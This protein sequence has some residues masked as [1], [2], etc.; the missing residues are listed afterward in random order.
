MGPMV[1]LLSSALQNRNSRSKD[2]KRIVFVLQNPCTWPRSRRWLRPCLL[3]QKLKKPIFKRVLNKSTRSRKRG[4]LSM[5]KKKSSTSELIDLL[6][7][8][9]NWN[10]SWLSWFIICFWDHFHLLQ[11]LEQYVVEADHLRASE[12]MLLTEQTQL[13]EVRIGAGGD[14]PWLLLGFYDKIS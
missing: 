14:G 1:P 12:A 11:E 3:Q 4:W 5:L 8:F 6:K 9:E 13:K 7:S 10:I 2:Q